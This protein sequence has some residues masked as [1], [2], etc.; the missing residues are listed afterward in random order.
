MIRS[1][2]CKET[3]I[4]WDGFV[5]KRFPQDIQER[6]LKRLR[7]LDAANCLEDLKNPPGN[8]LERLKGNME[9][10]MSVRINNQ[11]RIC[12]EW[13]NNEAYEVEIYDYH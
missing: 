4:I 6:A 1:F 12:F 9:G 10:Q 8:N 2:K 7:M 11:W 3:K 13:I 5:S